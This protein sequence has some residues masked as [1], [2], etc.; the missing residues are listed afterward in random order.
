MKQATKNL[1]KIRFNGINFEDVSKIEFAF[2]QDI[3][4][5]PL[6]TCEYPSDET[7]LLSNDVV[8]VIWTSE[9][10]KLFKEGK[11]FY[12]DTRITMSTTE[13]QPSTPVIRLKM[14]HTLFD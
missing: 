8:G 4:D 13:Y 1:L 6:K 14:E 12:C 7:E 10:T 2:S 5:A 3:D 11:Y 9:Q